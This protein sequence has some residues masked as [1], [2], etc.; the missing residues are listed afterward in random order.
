[1]DQNYI[2]NCI[3]IRKKHSDYFLIYVCSRPCFDFVKCFASECSKTG[4]VSL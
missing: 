3:A 2:T 4:I 1:M